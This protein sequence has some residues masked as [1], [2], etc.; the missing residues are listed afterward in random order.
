MTIRR[1][2]VMGLGLIGGSLGLALSQRGWQVSGIDAR[3]EVESDALALG[4][5]S[6]IGL[7]PDA[8]ITFIATPVSSI[9]DQAKL[10]LAKTKGLVTD[11][12]GVKVA[13]ANEIDD[14]RFV[15]GHPMAGSELVGLQGADATLFEDAVWV[16]T[17]TDSTADTSFASVAKI[18]GE[19]GAEIVVLTP[20]R[21]DQLIAVVSHLPHL[22]A[23]TLMG[24]ANNSA[25]EH[26][27]VLRL[28]A[29]GFRDMTRVASGHPD[30][31]IDVCRENRSAIL[32]ALDGMIDG[33]QS[34]R[35]I[36]DSGDDAALLKR[37]QTART[38]RA[39]LPGRVRELLDVVEVRIPIP[40][41]S[42]A[43]AEV[44]TLAAKLGVNVANFEVVHSV[45]GER[46]ILVVVI[47]KSSQ[48]IF[49][50]GL[51]AR[52]FRPTIQAVS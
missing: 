5:I 40:D 2:N 49:R 25:E 23:A 11:V 14:P 4:V 35:S 10:A 1:A 26:V 19:L 13:I 3:S 18:V 41:R 33:L 48:D 44:F 6:S 9:A 12:G 50:G 46:G 52:G 22:T 47:D 34:M 31:W 45:E 8:Q 29:G 43:A 42:G 28:A 7:D 38:A 27:A 16:L 51:I 21:H 30:I 15:G 32:T 39:N 24:L 17:P 36:V 37:L 20:A